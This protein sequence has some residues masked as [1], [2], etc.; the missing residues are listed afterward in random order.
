MTR[1]TDSCQCPVDA[2]GVSHCQFLIYK[3]SGHPVNALWGNSISELLARLA[4]VRE[5]R[6]GL[7]FNGV[8][9][10]QLKNNIADRV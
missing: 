8:S 1:T 4:I 7:R 3:V 5:T 10:V 2:A 6:S 9:K